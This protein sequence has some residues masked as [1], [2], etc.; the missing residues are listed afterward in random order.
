MNQP[1]SGAHSCSF[2]FILAHSCS[3]L[4]IPAHSCPFLP[5]PAHSCSFLLIPAHSCSF[6]LI[7]AHCPFPPHWQL[8]PPTWAGFPWGSFSPHQPQAGMFSVGSFVLKSKTLKD[9]PLP[10]PLFSCFMASSRKW[11]FVCL[12]QCLSVTEESLFRY[13]YLVSSSFYFSSK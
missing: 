7:P 9:L 5:I 11:F 12:F 6:L 2:L 8:L 3:F 10:P 13:L 1:R 4:P